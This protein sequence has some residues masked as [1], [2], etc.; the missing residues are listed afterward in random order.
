MGT[1]SS[2]TI[3]DGDTP[4]VNIYRQYDG[5][6]S[7]HGQEL[8]DFLKGIE[9]VNGIGMGEPAKQQANGAGCLAAQIITHFKST[10]INHT[11]TEDGPKIREGDNVGGIYIAPF[12]EP[13]E[14]HYDV[15]VNKHNRVTGIEVD[16]EYHDLKTYD[17][18][19]I[20][21]AE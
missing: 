2:T 4:L 17:G 13:Q 10:I 9:I 1:R 19:A 21:G 7:G 15:R 16:G 6:P 11:Y 20:E 3:H 14:Y 5:Y 12:G 8:V 18:K